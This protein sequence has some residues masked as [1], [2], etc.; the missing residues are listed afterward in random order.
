MKKSLNFLQETSIKVLNE[1]KHTSETNFKKWIYTIMRN[2]FI[3]NY[4]KVVREQTYVNHTENLYRLSLPQTSDFDRTES[5]YNLKD[6][7]HVLSELSKDYKVPFS[8]HIAGFKHHE[9]ADKL[10]LPLGTVKS[11]IFFIHR[12]LQIQLEDF[13]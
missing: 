4:R 10:G 13:R 7:Y 9:I 8:M 3:N 11:R 2:L 5:T 12:R 1:D 6:M